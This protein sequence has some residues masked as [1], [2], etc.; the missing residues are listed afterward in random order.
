MGVRHRRV[1]M[2]GM[3][4]RGLVERLFKAVVRS[5][6][7]SLDWVFFFVT[8]CLC[9]FPVHF[10]YQV[11]PLS[12]FACAAYG[13]YLLFYLCHRFCLRLDN[14]DERTTSLAFMIHRMSVQS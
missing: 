8:R 14:D 11:F 5:G 12:V 2:H 6:A 7:R 10:V 3:W 13:S 1:S 4:R 9:C